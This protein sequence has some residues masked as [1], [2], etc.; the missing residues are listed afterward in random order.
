LPNMDFMRAVAAG[1]SAICL[2]V[3][4]WRRLNHTAGTLWQL[5]VSRI[6]HRLVYRVGSG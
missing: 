1:I 4:P 5:I 3:A 6:C 2:V